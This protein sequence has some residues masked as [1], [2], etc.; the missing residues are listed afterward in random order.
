MDSRLVWVNHGKRNRGHLLNAPGS[1]LLPGR[2]TKFDLLPQETEMW[3]V[4]QQTQHDQVGVEAVQTMAHV[5][6]V[7]RLCACEAYVFHDLVLAL[8]WYLMA[9]ENDLDVAP[10]GILGD[11]L[12]DKVAKVR[13]KF[14]HEY[15]ACAQV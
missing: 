3:I 15:C 12:V 10:V 4:A 11:L 5:G 7:I 14:C 1:A 8:T 9:G 13:G 2:R 6:I